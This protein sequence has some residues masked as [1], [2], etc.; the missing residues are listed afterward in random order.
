VV[1]NGEA[2]WEINDFEGTVGSFPA[3]RFSIEQADDQKI[4]ENGLVASF[5][6]KLGGGGDVTPTLGASIDIT[7]H[8]LGSR[9]L[10]YIGSFGDKI[11]LRHHYDQTEYSTPADAEEFNTF[12]FRNSPGSMSL[13]LYVNGEL[14]QENIVGV[15]HSLTRTITLGSQGSAEI[16]RLFWRSASIAIPE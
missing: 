13:D 2:A 5:D 10:Y 6:I 12:E 4:G 9:W 1:E 16:G 14:V 3:Y 7:L 15:P 8:S 11:V